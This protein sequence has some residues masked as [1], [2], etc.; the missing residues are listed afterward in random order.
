MSDCAGCEGSG[1]IW[2]RDYPLTCMWCMSDGEFD[3]QYV[4]EFTGLQTLLDEDRNGTFKILPVSTESTSLT[5][6]LLTAFMDKLRLEG[7]EWQFH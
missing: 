4:P 6:N 1:V 2:F 5:P 3:E 7:E